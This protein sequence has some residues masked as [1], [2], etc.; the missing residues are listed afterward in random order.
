MVPACQN[1]RICLRHHAGETRESWGGRAPPTALEYIREYGKEFQ[2]SKCT[3]VFYVQRLALQHLKFFRG[4]IWTY[5][6]H[7]YDVQSTTVV[8]HVVL[9]VTQKHGPQQNRKKRT[10]RIQNGY[11]GPAKASITMSTHIKCSKRI[12]RLKMYSRHSHS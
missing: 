10:S 9:A 8:E 11:N 6:R 7:V 4:W 5:L 1:S 12:F 2:I 3:V